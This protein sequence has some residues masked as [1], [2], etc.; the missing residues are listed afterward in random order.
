LRNKF[1]ALAV[2]VPDR[3]NWI[4]KTS[5]FWYRKAVKGGTEFVL[6]DAE[7]LARKPAFDPTDLPLASA[8]AAKNHRADSSVF[9]HHLC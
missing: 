5:R 3:A 8:R 4:E 6:V 9:I 7:T 1:Q 2:N